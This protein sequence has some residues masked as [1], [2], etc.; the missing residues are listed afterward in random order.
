[1]ISQVVNIVRCTIIILTVRERSV[2]IGHRQ[3]GHTHICL[4][5]TTM[6]NIDSHITSIIAAL[7]TLDTKSHQDTAP[8][9]ESILAFTII[10]FLFYTNIPE[11]LRVC[12]Q[13]VQILFVRVYCGNNVVFE[14]YW[15]VKNTYLPPPLAVL[16]TW[17]NCSNNYNLVFIF[18]K[19]KITCIEN[20][21]Q[22]TSIRQPTSY[23][24]H[25][26]KTINMADV[27]P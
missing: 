2:D 21:Y 23:H 11:P 24:I 12:L 26:S 25:I 17:W 16:Y 6:S 10:S 14:H 1:M 3:R 8:M 15:S 18:G 27:C 5:V 19:L 9:L 7:I 20:K 13:E 4:H 22:D